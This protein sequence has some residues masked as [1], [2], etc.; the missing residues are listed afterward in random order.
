MKLIQDVEFRYTTRV[1]NV[2]KMDVQLGLYTDWKSDVSGMC[3]EM[4][5][6][7]LT[8]FPKI[9]YVQ[10]KASDE[11]TKVYFNETPEVICSKEEI[12]RYMKYPD[13]WHVININ[14]AEMNEFK[15]RIKDI[16]SNDILYKDTI[17]EQYKSNKKRLAKVL[18][19]Y[20]LMHVFYHEYGHAMDGHILAERNGEIDNN[21]QI[22]KALEY[23]A[24]LFAVNQMCKRFYF[25]NLNEICIGAN[26]I[27]ITP[28]REEMALMA[29]AVYIFLDIKYDR[30]RID[31]YYEE[32]KRSTTHM[33][34]FLR[35]YYIACQF[36]GVWKGIINL[37]EEN[38]QDFN[39]EVMWYLDA[40]ERAEH[41]KSLLESPFF[42]GETSTEIPQAQNCWNDIYEKLI[43]Y[44]SPSVGIGKLFVYNVLTKEF[45]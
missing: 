11:E 9:H 38:V 19:Q 28:I 12:E 40:Y 25:D 1:N 16:T 4:L 45:E 33:V 15:E 41:G 5:D 39:Q 21:N 22:S 18:Y 26:K 42:I 14:T 20:G 34:P 35:Q 27:T 43:P 36:A 30:D 6:C 44:V 7:M 32:I 31:S 3:R 13:G 2:L 10:I 24:D 37:S 29:L 17:L 8:Y 23:N